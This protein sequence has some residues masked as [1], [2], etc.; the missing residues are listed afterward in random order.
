MKLFVVTVFTLL[1][2]SATAKKEKEDVEGR[3]GLLGGPGLIVYDGYGQRLVGAG[4]P[5]L[6]GTVGSGVV[7]SGYGGPAGVVGSGVVAPVGVVGPEV[8]APAVV[9]VSLGEPG[10]IGVGFGGGYEDGYGAAHGA[11]AG[12]D[13]A[14]F[15]KGAAGHAQG[16]G[17]YAGGTIHRNVQAYNSQQGYSYTSGFSA[18]DTKTFGTGHQQGLTGYVNGAAGQQAGFGKSLHGAAGGFGGVGYGIHG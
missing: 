3:G 9:P 12:G 15:Q 17:R 16:S 14:G 2:C 13:Q 10:Y 5:A 4:N 7:A 8:Y 11:V 1:A 6:L 18:S